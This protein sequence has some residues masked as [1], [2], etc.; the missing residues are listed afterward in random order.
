MNKIEKIKNIK[1]VDH[2][3]LQTQASDV[4]E[5]VAAYLPLKDR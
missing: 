2:E 3:M 4:I 5:L 1:L